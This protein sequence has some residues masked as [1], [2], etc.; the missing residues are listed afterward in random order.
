MDGA[1]IYSPPKVGSGGYCSQRRLKVGNIVVLN[2][3]A[4]CQLE[5]LPCVHRLSDNGSDPLL[6]SVGSWFCFAGVSARLAGR[7]PFGPFRSPV[8][9]TSRSSVV[10][11]P[12]KWVAER[13][14]ILGC[15]VGL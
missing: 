15:F 4:K 6:E 8:L 12:G 11:C 14:L 1:S 9:P 3:H 13:L 2:F 7:P 5:G 10:H